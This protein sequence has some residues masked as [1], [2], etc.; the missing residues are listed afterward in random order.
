MPLLS[1]VRD[2]NKLIWTSLIN[3]VLLVLPYSVLIFY[4]NYI[5]NRVKVKPKKKMSPDAS[6]RR[7]LSTASASACNN[8]GRRNRGAQKLFQKRCVRNLKGLFRPESTPKADPNR[9]CSPPKC[10]RT[11]GRTLVETTPRI[12]TNKR[13]IRRPEPHC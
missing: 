10:Y 4:T 1:Y 12:L 5:R 8:C 2:I 11:Q 13:R 3:Y 9:A 6:G 7:G